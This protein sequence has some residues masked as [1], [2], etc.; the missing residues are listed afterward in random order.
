MCVSKSI[1]PGIELEPLSTRTLDFLSF[2]L[3]SSDFLDPLESFF[4]SCAF[5]GGCT[6]MCLLSS[7]TASF[8]GQENLFEYLH[9]FRSRLM[10][11]AM[12]IHGLQSLNTSAHDSKRRR[13]TRR[14]SGSKWKNS[15]FSPTDFSGETN[16]VDSRPRVGWVSWCSTLENNCLFANDAHH[17]L[18]YVSSLPREKRCVCVL[19]NGAFGGTLMVLP[20][21]LVPRQRFV[22]DLAL[23][24]LLE[25]KWRGVVISIWVFHQSPTIQ[26]C[27][28][29]WFDRNRRME[30]RYSDLI[31]LMCA[32]KYPV[33]NY[34]FH[35]PREC[36][37]EEKSPFTLPK[38]DRNKNREGERE[39]RGE[40]QI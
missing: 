14:K 6:T 38:C 2:L 39:T 25:P 20:S 40:C 12:S 32:S 3:I 24:H 16:W 8:G 5:P 26:V 17:P 9:G 29:E 35:N 28:E 27:S 23:F 30:G 13:R 4:T 31:F 18:V 36:A 19:A 7:F 37:N 22:L 33:A 11:W 34:R 21:P 1:V 15:N 10:I